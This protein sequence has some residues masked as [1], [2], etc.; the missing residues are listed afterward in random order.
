MTEAERND[1]LELLKTAAE[2]VQ[3]D[4]ARTSKRR[5]VVSLSRRLVRAELLSDE[6]V[7]AAATKIAV[8]A[9]R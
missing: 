6:E 2:W 3:L 7:I 8:E 4:V 5:L 1:A 9:L